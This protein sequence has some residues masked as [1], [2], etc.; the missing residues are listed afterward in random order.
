MDDKMKNMIEL[1]PKKTFSIKQA[2][3]RKPEQPN[4]AGNPNGVT[5]KEERDTGIST[6][7]KQGLRNTD[8]FLKPLTDQG[9]DNSS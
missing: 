6:R 9:H 3:K 7:H 4:I 8:L 5:D 2:S 1:L